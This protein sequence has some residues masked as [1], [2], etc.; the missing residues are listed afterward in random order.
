MPPQRLML[1]SVL[2]LMGTFTA[3]G[4]LGVLSVVYPVFLQQYLSQSRS[5]RIVSSPAGIQ[6]LKFPHFLLCQGKVKNINIS[7]DPGRIGGFRQDDDPL[8]Y[9]E[10][11]NDLPG[12]L[13]VFLR[14]R[15]DEW[16][17]KQIFVSVAK[18]IPGFQ[19]YAVHGKQVPQFPLL[20]KRIV[21][22]LIDGWQ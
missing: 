6:S 19:N 17:L 7:G 1:C 20:E 5:F 15:T 13:M 14:Q 22:H 18:G 2:F 10:T 3:V 4:R 11:Q 21:F 8:L 16:M 12:I 9:L